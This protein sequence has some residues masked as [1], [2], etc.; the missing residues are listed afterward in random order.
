MSQSRP[1]PQKSL[2]YPMQTYSK[3][4]NSAFGKKYEKS[5]SGAVEGL[6]V[7]TFMWPSSYILTAYCRPN[8]TWLSAIKSMKT[9]LPAMAIA[10]PRA[11]AQLSMIYSTQEPIEE[12]LNYFHPH[13]FN[14]AASFG[15]AAMLGKAMTN[16]L[17]VI[18]SQIAHKNKTFAEIRS[19]PVSAFLNGLPIILMRDFIC[20]PAYFVGRNK[21]APYV[22]VENPTFKSA[23]VGVA[24]G[25]FLAPVTITAALIA[26]T[27]KVDGLSIRKSVEQLRSTLT[28]AK[29]TQV[30][31]LR[32]AQSMLFG[33]FFSLAK[34]TTK[35]AKSLDETPAIKPTAKL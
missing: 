25:S 10:V 32:M 34:D 19:L 7:E 15:F 5:V 16:P 27:Q 11:S 17:S 18:E 31:P 9:A 22:T 33:L 13:P 20:L 26:E 14:T 35:Q 3:L 8:A 21:I 23:I 4:L 29:V 1:E 24:A 12:V 6:G 2:N 28:V 30:V